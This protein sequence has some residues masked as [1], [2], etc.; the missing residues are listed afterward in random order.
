[1][2]L[3]LALLLA[4]V[5]RRRDG[6]LPLLAPCSAAVLCYAVQAFFSFSVCIVAPVFW[7][8]LGISRKEEEVP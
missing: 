8:L 5:F 6:W 7:V 4:A 3:F 1:M 2:L